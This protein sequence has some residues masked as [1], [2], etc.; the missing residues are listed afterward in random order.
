MTDL[1]ARIEAGEL[2][3]FE[4][5]FRLNSLTALAQKAVQDNDMNAALSLLEQRLPGWEWGVAYW[6]EGYGMTATVLDPPKK[7]K[8]ATKDNPAA[9]LV[10]AIVRAVEAKEGE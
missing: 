6:G 7:F 4:K 10:A 1:A 9:A 5:V 8:A 3:S 2:L